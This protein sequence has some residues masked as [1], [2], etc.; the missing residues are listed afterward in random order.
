MK[1]WPSS[2]F[3]RLALLLVG[4]LALALTATIVLFRQDRAALLLRHF[5]DTKIVQLQSLR[6]SLESVP[7]EGRRETLGRLGRRNG[8]R[9]VAA[10]EREPSGFT[11]SGWRPGSGWRGPPAADGEALRRG[12]A[13][14]RMRDADDAIVAMRD[15]DEANDSRLGPIARLVPVLAQLE[16]RFTEALGPGVEVRAQPRT[17]SLWVRLPAGSNVYWVGFPL[18]PRPGEGNEPSRA[19]VISGSLALALIIAAFIFARYLSRP[20]R[21]LESAVARVGRGDTSALLPETGPSEIAAVNRGFNTMLANLRQIEHDRAVLLAGVSHDLRTPLARLRLGVELSSA[22]ASTR[23]GMIADIE[24]MDRVI[25]QFL[26]FARGEQSAT[27]ETGD[28]NQIAQSVA[29]RYANTGRDVRF[30]P[31]TLAPFPMRRTA[32]LR[33]IANLVDNALAYGAPPVEITTSAKRDAAIIEVVDRGPGIDTADVERL[34]RP[35]TRADDSRA[36]HDGAAGAGLGLAIVDRI[37]RLHGGRFDLLPRD[38]GGTIAR[39][40]LSCAAAP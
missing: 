18:P 24:E 1:L 36:R 8:V 4:V 13:R 21:Q 31:G 26:D 40:T 29:E 22:D 14:A 27:V 6:A 35:F 17:Q 2:L 38:G 10:D 5:G 34:K 28:L 19:L 32:I 11:S 15:A 23:H 3:G 33:L 37:A 20:L 16:S 9:I 12:E 7:T 30:K 25:G 39:V